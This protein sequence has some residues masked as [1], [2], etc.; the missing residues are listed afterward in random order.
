MKALFINNA[1]CTSCIKLQTLDLTS[2]KGTVTITK[3]AIKND[4]YIKK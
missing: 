3:D 2:N 1:F 4:Y